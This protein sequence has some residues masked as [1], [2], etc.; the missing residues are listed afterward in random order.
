MIRYIKKYYPESI[1][2]P[3][4]SALR[5]R[6]IIQDFMEG[7]LDVNLRN[8]IELSVRNIVK[9]EDISVV[10]FIPGSTRAKTILRFGELSSELSFSLEC[11][12][13]LDAITLQADADPITHEPIYHCKS[14]RVKGK[15]VLI[16]GGVYT[17]EQHH[18]SVSRLVLGYGAKKVE[19]LYIAKIV[20]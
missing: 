10:C 14:E 13:F 7:E 15:N 9:E 16:I 17:H 12:V 19:E 6:R 8:Q 18:A 20:N 4:D 5:D 2:A 3:D 11:D 1:E